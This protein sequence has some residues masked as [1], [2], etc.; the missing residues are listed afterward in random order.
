MFGL[1]VECWKLSNITYEGT[2]KPKIFLSNGKYN[3][4]GNKKT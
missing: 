1:E 3:I 4:W 2:R